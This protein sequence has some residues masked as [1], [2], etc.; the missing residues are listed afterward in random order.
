MNIYWSLGVGSA[1]SGLGCWSLVSSI[2][3][4]IHKDTKD[5][6]N[7]CTPIGEL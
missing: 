1:L 2:T 6:A 5:T 7:I 4:T 3:V